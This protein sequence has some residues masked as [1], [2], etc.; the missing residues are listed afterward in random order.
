MK[1]EIRSNISMMLDNLKKM[2]D[3][4]YV[5]FIYA[6]SVDPWNTYDTFDVVKYTVKGKPVYKVNNRKMTKS[7]VMKRMNRYINNKKKSTMVAL[8]DS[9]HKT[10]LF[11]DT[12][13]NVLYE[14]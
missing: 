1:S 13:K 2:D 6:D 9:S 14:Y 5:T 11:Y 4:S 3:G 8:K 7:D 10:E 12:D